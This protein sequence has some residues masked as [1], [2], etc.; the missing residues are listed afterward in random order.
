M[1]NTIDKKFRVKSKTDEQGNQSYEIQKLKNPFIGF[2]RWKDYEERFEGSPDGT[3]Y[4]ASFFDYKNKDEA[5]QNC[6]LLNQ[7]RRKEVK[8]SKTIKFH[9]PNYEVSRVL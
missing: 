5:I 7:G 6:R 3:Y 4:E 9:T 8:P 1:A 2:S